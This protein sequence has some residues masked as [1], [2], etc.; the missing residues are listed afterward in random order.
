M[1]NIH[2]KL[3][4]KFRSQW[5]KVK[6]YKDEPD[7]NGVKKLKN[8]RF[9]EATKEAITHSIIL[10]KKSISCPGAQHAF[11]WKNGY[12][13]ELLKMCSDKQK[14]EKTA[15]KSMFLRAPYFKKP[16]KYI[17]LN[18]DGEPDLVMSY[19][20]PSDIMNFVRVFNNKFGKNLECS[21]CSM[22]SICGGVAAAT[23][24]NKNI[25]ISFGC[26]DSRRLADMKR[27]ILAIG[28]PNRLFKVFVD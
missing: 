27:E 19:L 14:T 26:N 23:Y 16:F 18:T 8:V 25:N 12:K 20:A 2:R 15:L 1:T 10:D 28:I 7:L 21:L 24:L 6:F 11:G 9:C 13:D 22:M 5:I 3:S 4:E 17:G